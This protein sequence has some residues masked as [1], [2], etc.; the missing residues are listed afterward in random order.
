[1]SIHH[2]YVRFFY[3]MTFVLL[4]MGLMSLT[5]HLSAQEDVTLIRLTD[6]GFE[7]TRVTV[8]V[9]D[10]VELRNDRFVEH[11]VVAVQVFS[12]YLP[13]IQSDGRNDETGA[14]LQE[15]SLSDVITSRHGAWWAYPLM[16]NATPIFERS[17]PPGESHRFQVEQVGNVNVFLAD[18]PETYA[19]VQ[20]VSPVAPIVTS[21]PVPVDTLTPTP[22]ASLAST[23]TPTNTPTATPTNTPT[24]TPTNTPTAVPTNTPTAT[25]TNTPCAR[26]QGVFTGDITLVSGCDYEISGNVLVEQPGKL[27]IE[28]NVTVKFMGDYYLRVPSTFEAIGT[29]QQPIEI[30]SGLAD[31]TRCGWEALYVGYARFEHTTVSHSCRGIFG[32]QI[33][34]TRV[35]IDNSRFISNT[36]AIDNLTGARITNSEFEYNV[37][38]IV[39]VRNTDVMTNT[40][41]NNGFGGSGFALIYV[42]TG[43]FQGNLV[44]DNAGNRQIMRV[45]ENTELTIERN[46][47]E[48]NHVDGYGVLSIWTPSR[49]ELHSVRFNNFLENSASYDIDLTGGDADLSQNYWGTTDPAIIRSRIC[50]YYCNLQSGKA[51]FEPYLL[52]PVDIQ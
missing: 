43:R 27:T 16:S 30:V 34:G 2:S 15:I 36:R 40:F 37:E 4:L 32:G 50:D 41:K 45:E 8:E 52:S 21:T 24:A 35:Y 19:V 31:P 39:T 17:L 29:A 46:T 25:P 23:A 7:P 22:T 3:G 12:L 14:M 26:L 47:F 44:K 38:A 6:N 49:S 18:N 20:M 10:F 28:P 13:T 42:L 48:G 5:D 33:Q 9:G 1:M 51:S 11:T